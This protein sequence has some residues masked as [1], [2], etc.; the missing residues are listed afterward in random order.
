MAGFECEFCDQPPQVLQCKCPICLLVLREPYQATCCGKSF[1]KECVEQVKTRDGRCPT[2]KT[3]NFFS[4]PNKGLQQ[5]LYDFQVY[6]THK[7]K[8]CEWTGELRELDNHLNPDPPAD[9]SLEGCPF[10]VINCPLNSA[11]CEVRL[12]RKD[13]KAH[14][15]DGHNTSDMMLEATQLQNVK[16]ELQRLKVRLQ[17][18]EKEKLSLKHRVTE[19]EEELTKMGGL[20]QNSV[21]SC[22]DQWPVG[23]GEVFL[24]NF[25]Q[26]KKADEEW[27]S[28][29]FY[30]HPRGY[31]MCLRVHCNG[32][33]AGKDTH[34]SVYV[35]LM[36]G[37]FD[38]Q[39]KWP[40]QGDIT[41]QLLN[42]EG[43][44]GHCTKVVH[45]ND[46]TP[47]GVG[48]RVTEGTLAS[49]S[50]LGF[51]MFVSH[52]DLRPKLLKNNCL[53]FQISKIKLK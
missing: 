35:H 46:R 13:M 33:S 23:P 1:C 14:F 3:E 36:R 34:I 12:V 5:S 48:C 9:K 40:F 26:H 8:G 30:T 19:L 10:T 41:V 29:P 16:Q 37:G 6:C 51:P 43:S 22:S 31:K 38:D 27:Y 32:R 45:F 42:Q 47:D 15:A 53:R 7:S 44:R 21:L 4:Y 24:T 49:G 11:G 52:A 28:P 20:K 50:G 18:A 17:Q 2:C 25:E 39:L